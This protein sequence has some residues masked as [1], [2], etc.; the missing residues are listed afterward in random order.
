VNVGARITLG[1]FGA[2]CVG[3]VLALLFGVVWWRWI[4]AP[5]LIMSGWAAIGHLVTLDDD[6]PG[7]WSSPANSAEAKAFWRR[8]LAELTVKFVI[9]GGLVWFVVTDWSG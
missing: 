2:S 1:I 9:L 3:S 7:G 4:S 6:A 8:S 5:A